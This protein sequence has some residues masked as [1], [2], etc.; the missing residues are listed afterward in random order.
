M[1][2]DVV[3]KKIPK[4]LTVLLIVLHASWCGLER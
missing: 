2:F 3:F 1:A 4:I